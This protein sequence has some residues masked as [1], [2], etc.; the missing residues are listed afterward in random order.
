MQLNHVQ[1]EADK[2]FL[3]CKVVIDVGMVGWM[4]IGEYEDARKRER[5]LKSDALDAAETDEERVHLKE[6][7]IFEEFFEDYMKI[8]G[9]LKNGFWV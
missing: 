4:P 8:R 7:W 3:A 6:N 9:L 5:K 2:Q 1:I